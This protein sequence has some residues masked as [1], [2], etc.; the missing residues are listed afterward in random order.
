VVLSFVWEAALKIRLIVAAED[1][2]ESATSDTAPG[3]SSRVVRTSLH[4]QIVT[5]L[6]EMIQTGELPPGSVIS[7]STL[8]LNLGI[9]RTPLREALKVLASENLVQLRPHRTPL[10]SP[11]DAAEVAELFELLSIIEP[12]AGALAC[13]RASAA[14]INELCDMHDQMMALYAERERTKYFTFNQAIHQEIVRLCGNKVLLTTYLSLQTRVQRARS[15][16]NLDYERWAESTEEHER[17]IAAFR[18]HDEAAV[19][20]L[21][22]EHTRQTAIAVLRGLQSTDETASP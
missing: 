9:S 14:E 12:A 10:V 3:A 2:E 13:E 16:A 11:V 6:R 8:C 15:M 18:G 21:L 17:L 1:I 19:E 5:T 4:D 22:Y 7:E 20:K